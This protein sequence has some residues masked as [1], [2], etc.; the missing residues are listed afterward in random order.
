MLPISNYGGLAVKTRQKGPVRQTSAAR[1][2]AMD[3]IEMLEQEKTLLKELIGY[4]EQEIAYVTNG[5]ADTLE[6]SMPQKRK[7][8]EAIAANRS[9][10]RAAEDI[11][12][13]SNSVALRTLKQ[14]L[15]GLW[16][17]VGGLNETSKDLVSQR[18]SDIERRLE[19]FF[20]SLNKGYDKLGKASKSGAHTIKSGV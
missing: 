8:I 2:D 16:K 6:E 1:S 17:Q 11:G 14:E 12:D 18:L 20:A 3:K 4:L 9:I 5:D 10:L 15:A 7:I 19:P 13:R